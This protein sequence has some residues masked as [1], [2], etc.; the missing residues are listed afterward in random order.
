MQS[1]ANK[2][3]KCKYTY[4]ENLGGVIAPIKKD[5]EEV[6]IKGQME[7]IVNDFRKIK[8]DSENRENNGK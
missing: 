7:N 2:C 6:L 5:G 3:I 1:Q 8:Y 4:E